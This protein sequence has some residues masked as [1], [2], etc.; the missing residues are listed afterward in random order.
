MTLEQVKKKFK[1]KRGP[2]SPD[3]VD[4]AN[5]LIA[6][7]GKLPRASLEEPLCAVFVNFNRWQIE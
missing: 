1:L 2:Y 4:Y 7:M 5:R 6:Q 3:S